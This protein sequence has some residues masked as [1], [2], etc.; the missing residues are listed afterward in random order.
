VALEMLRGLVAVAE[1]LVSQEAI[2]LP[3]AL[4]RAEMALRQTLYSMQKVIL[5][6]ML[7]AVAVV[8]RLL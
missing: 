6:I 4:A 5:S 8:V 7:V 3:Q 2:L 1:V